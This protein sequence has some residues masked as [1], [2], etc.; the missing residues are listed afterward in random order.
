MVLRT[1]GRID[2]CTALRLAGPLQTE[3]A[4]LVE[5]PKTQ[6]RGRAVVRG[7]AVLGQ[8]DE[9]GLSIFRADDRAVDEFATNHQRRERLFLALRPDAGGQRHGC[10]QKAAGRPR[11]PSPRGHDP[12]PTLCLVVR[13]AVCTLSGVNGTERSR[14]PV[15]SKTAFEMADGTTAAEGSP[16]PHG[17][18]SGRSMRSMATSGISGKVRM[19]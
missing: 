1:A 13:M 7:N 19:G 4:V 5:L 10:A 3:S 18:S 12:D 8:T 2:G 6:L 15:A 14:A 17:F 16:P 11:R 9:R